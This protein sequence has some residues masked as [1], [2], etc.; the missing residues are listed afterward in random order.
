MENESIVVSTFMLMRIN[1]CLF[2]L[3]VDVSVMF[4]AKAG[5]GQKLSKRFTVVP[6]ETKVVFILKSNQAVQI[7][8]ILLINISN[9]I[10]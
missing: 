1:F 3:S 8:K 7:S 2:S 4:H 10:I 6:I 5:S 9:I